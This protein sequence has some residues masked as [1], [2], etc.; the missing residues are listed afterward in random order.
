MYLG[1]WF[2]QEYTLRIGGGVL[3]GLLWL[4]IAGPRRQFTHSQLTG[5]LWAV[6]AGAL[7]VGRVGYV[8]ENVAYFAQ[9]PLDVVRP[10]SVGGL[11]EIGTWLGGLAAAG[12]WAFRAK[13]PWMAVFTLLAPA[14]LL[15][16]AGG[17]WGCAAAG[18]AWGREALSV[19]DSQRWLIS[20]GPDLYHTVMPRYPVQA[21]GALWALAL[22]LAA[23]F[24]RRCGLLAVSLYLAG[25]AAL[26]FW[27]GDPV[28]MLGSQRLDTFLYLGLA[29]S[30]WFLQWRAGSISKSIISIIRGNFYHRDTES[31]EFFIFFSVFSVSLW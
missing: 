16:A 19:P 3:A 9:H 26:T 24:V 15:V 27:R 22:A 18:C 6:A 21:A 31:T 5:L 4:W 30:L 10:W 29:L 8:A 25:M 7:L 28:P 13:Q 11:H 2:V 17:G 20:N 12:I 23:M 14:A 1:P